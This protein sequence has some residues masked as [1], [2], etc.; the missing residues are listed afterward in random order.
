[1]YDYSTLVEEP[2]PSSHSSFLKENGIKHYCIPFI[3]NKDASVKTSDCVVNT[4]LRIMLDKA[5]HPMLIHC[6]KG[7]VSPKAFISGASMAKSMI[8][9]IVLGA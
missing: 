4:I 5:N 7:K 9:S 3:A 6:N 1:M 8:I 2:F